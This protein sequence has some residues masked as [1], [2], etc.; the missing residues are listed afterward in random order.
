MMETKLV[1]GNW[2]CGILA[3]DYK[4]ANL[5]VSTRV[6]GLDGHILPNIAWVK[7]T[8][9]TGRHGPPDGSTVLVPFL[10]GMQ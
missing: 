10:E 1:R 9:L 5:S 3:G 7:V 4:D 8:R 2:D 6:G